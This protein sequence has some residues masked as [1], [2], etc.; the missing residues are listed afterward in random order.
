[1]E[2]DVVVVVVVVLAVDAETPSAA[3][4]KVRKLRSW[5]SEF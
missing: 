2:A 3:M 4:S 5:I 1:V